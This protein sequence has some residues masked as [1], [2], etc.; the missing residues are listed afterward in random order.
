MKKYIAF[1]ALFF[2]VIAFAQKGPVTA[3]V[4][5]DIEKK[6]EQILAELKK[7][8]RNAALKLVVDLRADVHRLYES[9]SIA[10]AEKK[11]K[12]KLAESA[13]LAAG[14]TEKLIRLQ[15]SDKDI[16]KSLEDVVK[17]LNSLKE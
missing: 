5:K 6:Q 2:S 10:F 7:N 8:D 13:Y 9:A 17:N 12:F 3:S 11:E 15:Y 16:E 1:A 14:K 4:V